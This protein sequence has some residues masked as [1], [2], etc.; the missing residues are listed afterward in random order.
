[1]PLGPQQAEEKL[2]VGEALLFGQSEGLV[3][4]LRG[5]RCRLRSS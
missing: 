2:P 5:L 1:M 3:E 4:D